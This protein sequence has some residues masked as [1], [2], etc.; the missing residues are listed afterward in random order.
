MHREGR[1][2]DCAAFWGEAIRDELWGRQ[3]S[4]FAAALKM[5][6]C[7]DLSM[8]PLVENEATKARFEGGH[9]AAVSPPTKKSFFPLVERVT[10]PLKSGP[11]LMLGLA[12]L[13][14]PR[15]LARRL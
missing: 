1:I 13:V 4:P 8:L 15:R 10:C 6:V 3:P 14:L 5:G 2:T 12:V 9:R 7:S 11:D